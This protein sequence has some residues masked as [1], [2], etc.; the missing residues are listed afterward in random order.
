[1]R[2]LVLFVCVLTL[3]LASIAMANVPD[4]STS[5]AATA[6]HTGGGTD[7]LS[8]FVLP[9]GAGAPF[10][11]ARDAAGL[12]ADGTVTL[13]LR[14]SVGGG[15]ENFPAED[16]YLSSVDGG[17]IACVDGT[18]A[19]A[20]TDVNGMTVWALPVNAGGYSQALCQVRVGGDAL[21]SDAGMA[22]NFVSAD[23]NG[24]LAVDL[25]DVSNFSSDFFG[26]Y[27]FRSDFLGDG[28]LD[29][30]DVSLMAVGMGAGC[31]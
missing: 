25:V 17:L 22:L 9:N 14:N 28:V 16:L 20:P 30:N 23:I 13:F 29:L 8:L 4:L 11:L 2:V 18:I 15:I 27:N 31:N 5:T 1:M 7:A 21:T 26:A 3:G 6:Y 24:D 10:N 19:D 12:V